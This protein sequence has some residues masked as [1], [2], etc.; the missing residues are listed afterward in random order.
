MSAIVTGLSNGPLYAWKADGS[1]VP[2]WPLDEILGAGYPAAGELSSGWAGNEVASV[3]FGFGA[4]ES[5]ISAY[6]GSGKT[7]PG[8]PQTKRNSAVRPPTLADLNGD[9]LDEIITGEPDSRLHVYRP[10]GS[11]LPGWPQPANNMPL[12]S[13][14]P[15][16]SAVVDLDGD[17]DLELVTAHGNYIYAYHHDGTLVNGFPVTVKGS[18]L[19]R[20]F[21]TVGDVDGDGTSDLPGLDCGDDCSEKT[22]LWEQT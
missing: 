18:L 4:A 20:T 9:G 8:W 1:P 17:G 22:T 15:S 12:W 21:P 7:L 13:Y 5:F 16:T 2:R 10:D 14:Q 11:E 19:V 6:S 3:Y